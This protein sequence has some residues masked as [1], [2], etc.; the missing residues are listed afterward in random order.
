MTI[1]LTGTFYTDNWI[2][3]HLEPLARSSRVAK[4]IMVA[5]TRVPDIAKVEARYPSDRMRRVL[6][7]TLARQ[8]EF[9]RVVFSERPD[10]A[11][12]FHL[13]MNGML[14]QWA[15]MRTGA[16]S[17]Y[18]CGGGVREVE[19]G[20]YLTENR[21][22]RQLGKPSA[23]VERRL[24]ATVRDIDYVI[25]MGTSVKQYFEGAGARGDVAVI[26]GGFAH[27]AFSPRNESDGAEFDLVAV[28]RLSGVKRLEL[29]IKAVHE[30]RES[31]LDTTA[32][33][34][35][36]G[37]LMAD[38]RRQAEDLG[39]ADAIVFVGWSDDVVSWLR[40]ARVY[41][42]TSESEGLSQ[43]MIQAMLCGLPAVVSDV[44]DLKDVVRNGEN[45]YLI[46]ALDSALFAEAY[47]RLLTDATLLS[48]FG[49]QARSSAL[50]LNVENTAKKWNELL[51]ERR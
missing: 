41:T 47:R 34:V 12:G 51:R 24:L 26:P 28:S 49:Q 27:D 7:G 38:L 22:F 15:A 5:S 35:G 19:G 39:I 13:L 21:I 14:A 1:V 11:G 18:I 31:G 40:R 44:G 50:Q 20:G 2:A 16:R 29:L 4:V 8:V 37:P 25:T 6:G 36:D 33:I 30:L 32:A 46:G 17:L 48:T 23:F 45:G 9:V 10:I 43:S 42:L 3:T